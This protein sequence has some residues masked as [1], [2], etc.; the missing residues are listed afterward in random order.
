MVSADESLTLQVLSSQGEIIYSARL[1]TAPSTR[2]LELTREQLALYAGWTMGVICSDLPTA[3]PS[4]PLLTMQELPQAERKN[5]EL[6]R[7]SHLLHALHLDVKPESLLAELSGGGEKTDD[8]GFMAGVS[9]LNGRILAVMA[10]GRPEIEVAYQL[11]Q[12]LWKTGYP[13]T[14]ISLEQALAEALSR[15]RITSI[16]ESLATLSAHFPPHATAVVAAS[17]GRW[18]EFA[19]VVLHESGDDKSNIASTVREYLA[20]QANIWLLLL[21]G[22]DTT[23]GLRRSVAVSRQVFRRYGLLLLCT[24]A[25][26]GAILYL[27]VTYTSGITK[28]VTPI[29]AVGASIGI[30]AKSVGSVI[31]TLVSRELKQ[32]IFHQGEEEAMVGAITTLPPV[33][34][35]RMKVWK[36]RRRGVEATT[37]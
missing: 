14:D 33:A 9:Q 20:R 8:A 31:G 1:G 24:A 23:A 15:A 11:G 12:N 35:S 16:R 21:T 18:S 7:L 17:M 28:V 6:V 22:T 4:G 29:V 37:R 27:T 26:L 30:S 10:M 25:I 2:P 32:P 36:L 13:R 5:L 34:L 19:G 3:A